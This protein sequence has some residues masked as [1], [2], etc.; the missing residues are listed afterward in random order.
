MPDE[1]FEW[2]E[3]KAA[4]NRR[5][6]GITFEMAREAFHDVFAVMWEDYRHDA[7][8]ERYCM[9]G[10]VGNHLLHVSYTFRGERVRIISARKAEPHERRRYHNENRDA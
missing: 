9:L 1:H 10:I 2:R 3:Q 8:E 4:R 6:H 7:Q 5:D